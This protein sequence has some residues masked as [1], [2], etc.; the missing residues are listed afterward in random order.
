MSHPNT[1][2][3]IKEI[4]HFVPV[5]FTTPITAKA[6][7]MFVPTHKELKGNPWLIILWHEFTIQN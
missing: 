6:A 2:L 3:Y 5:L 7:R 1:H 4:D